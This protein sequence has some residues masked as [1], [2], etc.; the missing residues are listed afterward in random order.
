MLTWFADQGCPKRPSETPLEYSQ[1]L[2]QETQATQAQAA[3]EIAHAYVRWRY[4][5][6]AQ[7]TAYLAEKLDLIHRSRS[8]KK[9]LLR[10]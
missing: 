9:R 2:Y 5:G 10:V 4:G 1:R 8:P 3:G 7:N 6:E